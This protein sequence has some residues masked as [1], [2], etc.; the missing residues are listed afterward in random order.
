MFGPDAILTTDMLDGVFGFA[1]RRYFGSAVPVFA[2][3]ERFRGFTSQYV[4][5]GGLLWLNE[6]LEGAGTAQER[7]AAGEPEQPVRPRLL[8]GSAS[9][10][11]A[12]LAKIHPEL[13]DDPTTCLTD[14]YMGNYIRSLALHLGEPVPPQLDPDT[15]A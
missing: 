12:A 5:V 10:V 3:L 11:K 1:A 7:M 8:T 4:P 2:P 9:D 6:R 13:R 14:H 15:C